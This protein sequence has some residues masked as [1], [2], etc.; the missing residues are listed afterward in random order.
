MGKE[1]WRYD[2]RN[3]TATCDGWTM[4]GEYEGHWYSIKRN[5]GKKESGA[6][7]MTYENH[8]SYYTEITGDSIEE[9]K[10]FAFDD[11]DD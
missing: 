8:D 1:V 11:I 6:F 4:E 2:K 7:I 10:T 3:V 5:I 9:L